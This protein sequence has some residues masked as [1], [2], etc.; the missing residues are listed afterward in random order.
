M[1]KFE[2]QAISTQTITEVASFLHRWHG[3]TNSHASAQGTIP[4]ECE[5]LKKHLH[6]LLLEN[7]LAASSP[8]HGFCARNASGVIVGL[9]L[10]F[11]N[12]FIVEDSRLL[13]SCGGS[14]FVEQSA[15]IQGF[16]LFKKYLNDSS[17][18]FY[19][20]TTCNAN[21]GALWKKLGGLPVPRSEK[22]YIVP[23]NFEAVLP[24]FIA[25]KTSSKLATRAAGALG[26]LATELTK[27]A[28]GR[29]RDFAV[30]PC[31][32][33]QKLSEIFLR[34]RPPSCITTYRSPEFLKWRYGPGSP[35][36][37]AETCS[38]R[39]KR[40]NEGW[41]VIAENLGGRTGQM[42][43]ALLL[44]AVWPHDKI[45]FKQ[46]LQAVLR[47]PMVRT[48]DALFLHQRLGVN[49]GQCRALIIPRTLPAPRAFEITRKG[50]PPIDV[51]K[52][53]LVPA[54]GDS[55]WN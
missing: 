42:R 49:Y 24:A 8:Q 35:N 23:V 14:F 54:D 33:W 43:G 44:D 12:A 3:D 2:I 30:E 39:D 45:E 1:E 28:S 31:Q 37:N 48:A 18:D 16:Y 17:C 41:F 7:P 47:R 6:W 10:C 26:Y 21:S 27:L 25:T 22:T 50:L 36:P 15:R 11:P 46:L 51:S 5:R 13:G 52:L 29:A 4:Q 55:A 19:F 38:F 34:H 40:G 20:G 32:D 9:L 53:D